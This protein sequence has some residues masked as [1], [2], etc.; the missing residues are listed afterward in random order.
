MNLFKEENSEYKELQPNE[1]LQKR[2]EYWK[3]R[4][5]KNV[6]QKA[7]HDLASLDMRCEGQEDEK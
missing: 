5:F 6:L 2:K 7:G 1:D 4:F 3:V